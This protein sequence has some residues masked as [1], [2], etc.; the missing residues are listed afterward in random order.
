MLQTELREFIDKAIDQEVGPT[1]KYFV[2]FMPLPALTA[3]RPWNHK[4]F[5]SYMRSRLVMVGQGSDV[6]NRFLGT[7]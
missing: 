6:A 5:V 3:T 7:L 1:G 4:S 2:R